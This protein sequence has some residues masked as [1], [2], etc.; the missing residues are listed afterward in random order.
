MQFLNSRKIVKQLSKVKSFRSDSV[1][2]IN[3]RS[4]LSASPYLNASNSNN[5]NKILPIINTYHHKSKSV[6]K[7][8]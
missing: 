3:F 7:E 6:A 4:Q 8:L 2:N 5:G 1:T